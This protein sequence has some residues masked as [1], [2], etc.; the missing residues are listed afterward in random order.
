MKNVKT[1]GVFTIW[2]SKV[3][4]TARSGALWAVQFR[5]SFKMPR[6]LTIWKSRVLKSVILGA[7]VAV[8]VCKSV[9]TLGVL[10]I[11]KSKVLKL[12]APERFGQL[13]FEQVSK[14]L[15]L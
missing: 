13:N 1:L 8:E 15:V 10:T 6:A 4:K 12:P 2:K 7:L 5:T 14:R 9:K 11:W 3:F